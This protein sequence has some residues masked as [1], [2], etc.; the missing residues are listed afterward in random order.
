MKF[1]RN[2][3]K[4]LILSIILTLFFIAAHSTD[5]KSAFLSLDP[6]KTNFNLGEEFTISLKVSTDFSINAVK[7]TLYFPQDKLSVIEVS[8][9]GSIFSLWPEEPGF[10]NEFGEISFCGGIPHPGFTGIDGQVLSVKFKAKGRG[11]IKLDWGESAILA[12]DGKGTNIFTHAKEAKYTLEILGSVIFSSTHSD[13]EKWYRDNNPEFHWELFPNITDV[14]FALN[15]KPDFQLDKA[16]EGRM[17][18]KVYQE[19]DDGIWYFHLRAKDGAGSLDG[20][21][22]WSSTRHFRVCIDTVPP[23]PFE[24]VV[25][26]EGDPTNPQPILYFDVSDEL[27]G[28]GYYVVELKPKDRVILA[29]PGINQYQLPTQVPGTHQIKVQA[30]DKAGNIRENIAGVAIQP[31]EKPI[32]ALWPTSY[33]AGEESFYTEGT[34]IPRVEI[35]LFLEKDDNIEREWQAFADDKGEWLF[36]TTDLLKSGIYY[37]FA[38]ARDERGAMS[39]FSSKEKIEV[40]LSGIVLGSFLITFKNLALILGII[41]LIL[42]IIVAC[43]IQQNLK[44]KKV[45]KK[46]TKEAEASLHAGFVKLREDIIKELKK[47]EGIKSKRELDKKEEEIIKNLKEDLEEVEKYIGKEIKDIINL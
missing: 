46:E 30:V 26:N 2:M 40:T 20:E 25:N 6:S 28:I 11:I 10:S 3:N 23:S 32:I 21:V 22:D 47:L 36:S 4:F 34:S 13:Q 31:I 1:K 33:V 38:K 9:E 15:K 39:E 43:F 42:I 14:S 44:T 17:N 5:A 19:L 35:Q 16:S 12:N 24:I 7:T 45:L 37:L 27:S 29:N 8:K 41:L 18:S